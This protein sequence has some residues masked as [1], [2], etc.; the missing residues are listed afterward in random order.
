MNRNPPLKTLELLGL[1]ASGLGQGKDF[2][3]LDWVQ[4][5]LLEKA[6]M[7]LIPGTFNLQMQ[8]TA[9][10]REQQLMS[11]YAGIAIVPPKGFCA[12]KCFPVLIDHL[13]PG[14]AI[15]PEV[16]GYPKEKLEI[17]AEVP[18]RTRLKLKDG[19]QVSLSMELF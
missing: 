19:D 9:W 1:V 15:I 5:Q 8:G 14:L 2:T 3:A 11:A 12:A 13:I 6:G 18:V 10:E 16:S 17:V 4:N 7:R